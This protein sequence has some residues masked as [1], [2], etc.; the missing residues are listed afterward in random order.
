MTT[1][2]IV[3]AQSQSG[4]P[5]V[6]KVWVADQANGTY[7][8]PI[9]NADYSDPDVCRVGDDYYMTASSF[10]CAPAIPI[11]HSKD[12]VNWK[13]V[14]Y[15][16]KRVVPDE[17]FS[18]PMHGKGVWAPC[19]SYHK[20][21]FYIYWGDPDYGIYMIKTKDPFGE[22][23]EPVL[24]MAGK[25][26]I[27]SSPLWDDDGR[28]Y[29]VHG[30]A[31]SRAGLNSI[32]TVNE[33]SADGS[34][35]IGETALVYDGLPQGNSTTEGPKFYKRNGFYYIM[36]PAGGVEQGWQIV[37]RSKNVYGPY[38]CRTVMA[39]GKTNINGPHQG[40][41]VETQT[42]ESWFINFQDKAAYGRVIH[43]QPMKWIKD[44]PVIGD[45]KDCDGCGEPVLTWKKPNVGKSWPIET[46]AESD[47][48]NTEKL[49]L[50]WQWHANPKQSTGMPSRNGYYRLYA[51]Y[52]PE[53]YI[54]FWQVPNLLLQKTPADEFTAT[55]KVDF[56]SQ[57]QGEKTGLIVMG[58]NYSH[59]SLVKKEKGYAIEQ[60]VC[61]DAEKGNPEKIITSKGISVSKVYLRV[62]VKSG[63]MC[64]FFYSIDGKTFIPVCEPFKARQGKWI[65]A[66]VG[67]Y[68]LSPL[69]SGPRGY[70][71]LDWFHVE[72][73]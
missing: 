40:G 1:A 25:G 21:E 46:P 63:A 55:V 51:E 31:A 52:T 35:V 34:K 54:N 61:I 6:S 72:K 27:D 42:G 49:G 68:C 66:K 41:W 48:F 38:E 2:G 22:W 47:E 29:L 37:M 57:T 58:W 32:L 20:G 16:M 19:I 39:Q 69:K 59:L 9:I 67:M 73:F 17:V 56:Y 30:W 15:A 65:G 36:A 28:V 71:D 44:W 64:S 62:Q 70:A 8:N 12:L 43:L 7:K 24:V 33:L 50:Q 45:D 4:T 23:S 60:A 53:D 26:L 14:N 11:L 13:L 18:K 5:Y 3:S 10:G